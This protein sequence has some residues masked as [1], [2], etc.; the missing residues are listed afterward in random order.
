[1]L[2]RLIVGL[3][4]V[5][6]LFQ[7][8]VFSSPVYASPVITTENS[9][10]VYEI[11]FSDTILFY[12]KLNQ[13]LN[14]NEAIVIQTDF[15]SYEEFPQKLKKIVKIDDPSDSMDTVASAPGGT[16]TTLLIGG[17][18]VFGAATGLILPLIGVTG[19]AS[20]IASGE[21]DNHA[22]NFMI[23]TATGAVVGGAIGALPGGILALPA[24]GVGAGAGAMF[25]LVSQAFSDSTRQFFLI[26]GVDRKIQIV[27]A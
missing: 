6:L 16:A 20:L 12:K 5:T 10:A 24:A 13:A 22:L 21:V 23:S 4:S 2:K 11:P 14:S 18:A 8:L 27:I 15:K 1:M 3:I 19:A 9:Q 17:A 26:D 7:S 25:S